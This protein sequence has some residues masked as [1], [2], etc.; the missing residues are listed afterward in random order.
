[1]ARTGRSSGAWKERCNMNIEL[2]ERTES[3]VRIYFE[4]VQD[5]EIKEMLPQTAQSAEQ[6]VAEFRKTLLPGAASFGRTIY[7]DGKYVGDIWC[8]CID[9]NDTPNAMLSYCVFEKELWG[10]GIATEALGQFVAEIVPKFGL[11]TLG[12]FAYCENKAS[13]RVLEKNGFASVETFTEDGV[14]SAYYER[15]TEERK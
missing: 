15:D 13:Q 1:M 3:H 14:A 4:K 2:R 11:K 10:K 9:L 12:A 7:A 6:V 8:Y 5:E